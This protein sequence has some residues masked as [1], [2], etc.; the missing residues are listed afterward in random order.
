MIGDRHG[1]SADRR[2]VQRAIAVARSAK[3]PVALNQPYAGGYTLDRHADPRHGR[4]A[5][6]IELDRSLYLDPAQRGPGPGLPRM[7]RLLAQIAAALED[8]ARRPALAAE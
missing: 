2:F 6:Q 5:L 8:E 7:R 3:L 4:H 1:R